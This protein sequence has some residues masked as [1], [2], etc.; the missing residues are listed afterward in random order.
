M[1]ILDTNV[2]SELIKAAVNKNVQNWFGD[3]PNQPIFL[4][5]ITVAEMRFGVRVL[6]AGRRQRDLDQRLST[7]LDTL[8]T[9]RILPFDQLAAESYAILAAELRKNG[10][11]IDIK[12]MMIAAITLQHG[13]TIVTRNT[14]HFIPCGV[15]VI[16]PFGD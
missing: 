6:V 3:L 8:F 12:D 15:E 16:N 7:M 11:P 9:D 13:A 5:A 2:T 10:T 4:T 14:K 1:I